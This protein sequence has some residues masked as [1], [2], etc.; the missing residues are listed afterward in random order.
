MLGD[1]SYMQEPRNRF[2]TASIC[3]ILMGTLIGVFVLQCFND[4]YLKSRVMNLLAL[5]PEAIRHGFVWQFLTFQFLHG[6]ILHLLFNLLGIWFFGRFVES[7][8]GAQRF[9]LAYFGSGILGGLLQASLMVAFPA[10][11]GLVVYGASAGVSGVFAIFCLLLPGSEIRLNFILPVR[12]DVLLWIT[13]AIE[14]FFTL[15]PSSRG[16]GVAH[17]AHLGG[18]L[19]GLAF[20]KLNWHQDFQPLPWME[21]FSRLGRRPRISVVRSPVK[22]RPRTNSKPATSIKPFVSDDFVARE[23]DPILDKIAAHGIH[24]LTEREREILEAARAKMAKR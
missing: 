5:T 7:V 22:E 14:L 21:F 4:V 15:V 9:L 19:A 13:G 12:A 3:T 6:H 20:V 1:R 16:G 10:H 11:F 17:A 8:L 23:V 24:S 2:G 18:L